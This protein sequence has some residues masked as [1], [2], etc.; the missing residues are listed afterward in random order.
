MK[1]GRVVDRIGSLHLGSARPVSGRKR[2]EG[3]GEGCLVL[4]TTM[5]DEGRG[6]A[7]NGETMDA[8]ENE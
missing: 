1:D 8:G 4:R 7:R 3:A 5:E 2:R 6:E